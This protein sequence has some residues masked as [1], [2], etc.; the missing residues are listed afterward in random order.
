M[1]SI[2][3]MRRAHAVKR[4]HTEH[5]IGSQTIADHSYGVAMLTLHMTHGQA[6]GNLLRAALYH[7]LAEQHTG[8]TPAPAKWASNDLAQALG[9]MEDD[10]EKKHG[11]HVELTD[12]EKIIL[13]WADS[14]ELMFYC[15]EQRKLGNQY[16]EEP[17]YKVVAFLSKYHY[18]Q[19]GATV[20]QYLME[21]M[22]TVRNNGEKKWQ[23]TIGK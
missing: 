11:I 6:S 9:S 4:Y 21:E 7:D 13:K 12:M 8:D 14:L 22:S 15:L 10:F 18:F 19:P 2:S 5:T 1:K 16:A 23:Q 20:M 3:V 17:F